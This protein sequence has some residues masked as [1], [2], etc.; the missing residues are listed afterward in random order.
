MISEIY[1]CA[2]LIFIGMITSMMLY[3]AIKFLQLKNYAYLYY[4]V[5]MVCLIIYFS[6]TLLINLNILSTQQEVAVFSVLVPMTSYIFYYRFGNN[7]LELK[8][9][10]PV[11]NV[12]FIVMQWT[13]VAF[14]ISFLLFV[15]LINQFNIAMVM[16]DIVRILLLLASVFAIV[17]TFKQKQ[18]L[19]NYFALGSSFLVTGGALAFVLSTLQS[20]GMLADH[21]FTIPLLYFMIGIILELMCFSLGLSYKELLLQSHNRFIEQKLFAERAN[22]EFLRITTTMQTRESERNRIAK[23][24]HDDLGSGLTEIKL[25]SEISKRKIKEPSA[26]IEKIASS[27]SDLIDKL[28]EIVWATNP[29]H[30]TLNSFLTYVRQYAFNYLDN[31]NINCNANIVEVPLVPL[32]SEVRRNLFLVVKE[33]LHNIVKY[34]TTDKVDLTIQI[35][36]PE[37]NENHALLVIQI[38]DYGKGFNS[39]NVSVNSNGLKNMIERMESIG[40]T[41]QVLA[42][43]GV[44]ITLTTPLKL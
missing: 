39:M 17:Y 29:R 1:N 36:L 9:K 25:L 21:F 44:H 4:T 23:E 20:A 28:S 7:F 43:N 16:H 26:E 11:L 22:A 5:Y 32:S 10:L 27:S 33:A 42:D 3:N 12:F 35:K 13:L 15:F 14:L 41:F 38:N 37:K 34:A 6:R 40:G 24:L 8:A 18:K 30:D 2:N 31:A 19:T